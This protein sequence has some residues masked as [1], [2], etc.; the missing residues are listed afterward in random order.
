MGWGEGVSCGEG[1][2]VGLS[3]HIINKHKILKQEKR[4]KKSEEDKFMTFKQESSPQLSTNSDLFHN[5]TMIA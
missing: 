5:K 4:R 1:W 3:T 2:S